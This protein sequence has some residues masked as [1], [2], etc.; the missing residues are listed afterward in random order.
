MSSCGT[1]QVPV[2]TSTFTEVVTA[3]PIEIPPTVTPIPTATPVP[4]PTAAPNADPTPT[5]RPTALPGLSADK[6]RV[7]MLYDGDTGGTADNLFS[8]AFDGVN[9]W[10]GAV[11]RGG[12]IGGRQ[13]ELTALDARISNFETR[14]AEICEGDFFAI[15][16]SHSLG[17]FEGASVLGTEECN[18]ADFAGNVY[19]AVHA[20]SP[21]TF[22][23]NPFQNDVRQ[24]GPAQYL[25]EK[26]PQASQNLA[27]FLY[28]SYQLQNETL[29]LKEMLEASGMQAVFEPAVDLAEDL[30]DEIIPEWNERGVESL[31]WNAD[32]QRLIALLEELDEPPVFV[33]C[34]LACYSEQFLVDGGDVVEG[35]YAW[36]PH[37]PFNS[38][39][40]PNELET[41]QFWIEQVAPG[42]G[43]SQ[44]SLESWMAGRLFEQAMIQLMSVEESFNREQLIDS[45]RATTAWDGAGLL[46]FTNP[47]EGEPTPCFA[48]MV[49]EDGEWVQ[50]YPD[51][52]VD[53]R[54]LDCGSDNLVSLTTTASLGLVE[55]SSAS[56][57]D[58]EPAS[59]DP[60]TTDQD[61]EEDLQNP[62]DA[63]E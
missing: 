32:P 6:I 12:G 58:T 11:N 33:L 51:S 1:P 25:V 59:N 3:T 10:Q 5:P 29:R 35:V 17:D 4:P 36:I 48:L 23:S 38:E 16:G 14:L 37:R 21:V 9:A 28:T 41:Y 61:Q 57:E 44:V 24:A 19:S 20:T 30:T 60:D 15:I 42:T 52:I 2:A 22:V 39:D 45:A 43:F 53:Q 27:L 49:V 7:A 18:I 34:E 62:E 47:G 54:D 13:V 31:V 63:P 46:S 26:Y 55:A 8:A 50:A 40:S 56:S